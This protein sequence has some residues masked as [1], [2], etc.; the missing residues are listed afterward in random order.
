MSKQVGPRHTPNP[1]ITRD[2]AWFH[3][4]YGAYGQLYSYAR[5]DWRAF[6]HVD[7]DGTV[8]C[9]VC[10]VMDPGAVWHLMDSVEG[11]QELATK[12]IE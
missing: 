11:A 4:Q 12:R 10:G 7:W 6:V 2:G 9:T 8:S 1:P 3:Q 5:G